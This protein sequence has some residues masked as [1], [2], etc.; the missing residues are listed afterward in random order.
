M[1]IAATPGLPVL[2]VLQALPALL[3]LP[4]LLVTRS[5]QALLLFSACRPTGNACNAFMQ[6]KSSMPVLLSMPSLMVTQRK[7][8]CLYCLQRWHTDATDRYEPAAHG[9]EPLQQPV[10]PVLL[11]K[12]GFRLLPAI[13]AQCPLVACNGMA[14]PFA[15]CVQR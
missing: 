9:V 10:L 13:L 3:A 1:A 6:F 4:M 14:A 11:A 8:Q 12:M 15:H 2:Q 5:L 7:Q